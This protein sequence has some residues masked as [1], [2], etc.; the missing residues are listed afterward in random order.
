MPL[1]FEL[2][3]ARR[4]LLLRVQWRW[5]LKARNGKI[6]ATRGESYANRADAINAIE[7]IRNQASRAPIDLVQFSHD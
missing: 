5:R 1:K 2:Y 6:I 7:L 3:R 4:G